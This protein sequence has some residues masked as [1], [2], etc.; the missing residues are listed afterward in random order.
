MRCIFREV[1]SSSPS[2]RGHDGRWKTRVYPGSSRRPGG[3]ELRPVEHPSDPPIAVH[4]PT[5]NGHASRRPMIHLRV[6]GT[7][8]FKGGDARAVRAI[9]S[10][11]KRAAVLVY[12]ALA[13]PR[14]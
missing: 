5:D 6:L 4:Y 1:A 7:L 3:A 14:G 13:Q 8:E 9:L 11:P 2:L 10:Q 12:L